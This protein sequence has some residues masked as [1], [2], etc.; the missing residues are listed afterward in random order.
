MRIDLQGA[1]NESLGS[2]VFG[3][4]DGGEGGKRF[5]TSDKHARIDRVAISAIEDISTTLADYQ[6]SATAKTN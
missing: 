6:E 5:A 1:N 4:V 2:I 3:A